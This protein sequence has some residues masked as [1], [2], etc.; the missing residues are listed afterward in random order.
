MN[1]TKKDLWK[2]LNKG[3][4][5]NEIFTFVPG[6][7]CEIYKAVDFNESEMDDVIYIPDTNLNEIYVGSTVYYTDEI[8]NI[9]RNCYTK[10]DFIEECNGNEKLAEDLFDYVDW[11]H[12]WVQDL[13]DGYDESDA[14]VFYERYG[15]SLSEFE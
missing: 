13:L 10:R 9:L 4:P 3:I 12:P 5:L 15:C 2:M 8:E 1:V 14:E 11:Q 6:Q 7:D